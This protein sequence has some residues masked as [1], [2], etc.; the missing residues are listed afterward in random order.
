MGEANSYVTYSEGQRLGVELLNG[1]KPNAAL[2]CFL[3]VINDTTY[4]PESAA[5]LEA[6]VAARREA[7]TVYLRIGRFDEALE[8]LGNSVAVAKKKGPGLDTEGRERWASEARLMQVSTNLL[9]R[10]A[11]HDIELSSSVDTRL[12]NY[13]YET[14][15]GCPVFRAPYSPAKH[16]R[17]VVDGLSRCH[18]ADKSQT[19]SQIADQYEVIFA[20]RMAAA[21]AYDG[22]RQKALGLAFRAIRLGLFSENEIRITNVAEISRYEQYQRKLKHTTAGFLAVGA[23]V[24]P[25]NTS[26]KL[27]E[28]I[29]A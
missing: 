13:P 7:G 15:D 20:S 17:K 23:A 9:A 27:I 10:S 26:L 4:G 2:A 22:S 29:T 14:S 6:K 21:E 8:S 3:Q 5:S 24:A 16:G 25:R 12:R 19:K 28:R 11:L 18:Q 1:N